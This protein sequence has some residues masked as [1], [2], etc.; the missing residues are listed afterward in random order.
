M[1]LI[2][3]NNLSSFV[4]RYARWWLNNGGIAELHVS[5]AVK[6]RFIVVYD[7]KEATVDSLLCNNKESTVV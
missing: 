1:S 4:G 3:P 7:K 2:Y 5:P 6:K